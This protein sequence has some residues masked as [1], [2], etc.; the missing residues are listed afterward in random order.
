M[1]TPAAVRTG[2]AG[3]RTLLSVAEASTV[4]GV[5]E[6]TVRRLLDGREIEYLRISNTIRIPEEALA[7]YM[8]AATVKPLR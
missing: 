1:T 4:L 5:S 3:S 6:M 7:S 8:D 2:G